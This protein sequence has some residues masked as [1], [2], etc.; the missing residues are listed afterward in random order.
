MER[1]PA[2]DGGGASVVGGYGENVGPVEAVELE[3]QVGA[4]EA[5][6]VGRVVLEAG[7][8]IAQI[9]LTR[10]L[11]RRPRHDLH[12]AT[13]AAPAP[14]QDIE[15]AFLACDRQHERHHG[16]PA[17]TRHAPPVPLSQM[18][19]M[20]KMGGMG[21]MMKMM[22]GLGKMA[23][24]LDEAGIDDSIMKKQEAIIFSMTK[25]ERE[26][27]DLLN[28]SRKKR[29]A[30]G[31]GTSVQEINQIA[32]QLKQMQTMMKRMKKMG[33]AEMMGMMKD[34][35]GPGGMESLASSMDPDALAGDMAGADDGEL[36]PNPFA[37]GGALAGQAMPGDLEGL[38]G[39][40]TGKKSKRKKKGK[41]K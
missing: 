19:Q 31:S 40:T 15:I 4:A 24:Q 37:P 18:Q 10:D 5:H 7:L 39:G 29:I 30:S 11:A 6:V 20:K 22:P 33:G 25:K 12:H 27:P 8:R 32:K 38:L 16:Q 9:E 3:F 1:D 26:K 23:S 21:A 14:G 41:R 36:G 35:M 13:R 28:A 17:Q 34:M 2:L